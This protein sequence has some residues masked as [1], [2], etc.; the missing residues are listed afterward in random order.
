MVPSS[1]VQL[2]V[3]GPVA[4]IVAVSVPLDWLKQV[5]VPVKDW[6]EKAACSVTVYC[7]VK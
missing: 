3:T 4:A 2:K 7:L 1:N 5:G 6:I